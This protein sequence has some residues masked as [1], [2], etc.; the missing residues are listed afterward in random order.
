MP[1]VISLRNDNLKPD[2]WKQIKDLIG[3]DF[4]IN[5]EAFTLDSLIKL[6]AQQF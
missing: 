2:H 4:N 1:V 3:Q 6:N 5:D